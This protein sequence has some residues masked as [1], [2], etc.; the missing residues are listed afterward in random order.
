[1]AWPV[2]ALYEVIVA[3]VTTA[4]KTL[5]D[6]IQ[7]AIIGVV[8]GGKSIKKL[9]VDGVGDVASAVAA[10]DIKVSGGAY[11]DTGGNTIGIAGFQSTVGG[12]Q[13]AGDVK[14]TGG[15]CIG[16]RLQAD[17]T[18][19][20]ATAGAGQSLTIGQAWKDTLPV[21]WIWI[22]MIAGPSCQLGRGVNIAAAVTYNAAGSYTVT[23]TNGPANKLL[24]VAT[25][26]DNAASVAQ[27]KLT[28]HTTTSFEIN[29]YDMA[30]VATDPAIGGGVFVWL[31]GG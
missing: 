29:V 26:F 6:A 7:N 18:R 27:F 2:D 21:G 30:G 1:M 25:V 31:F 28:G 5:A 3:G 9:W 11:I 23:L 12:V 4:K 20:S 10:G 19:S 16:N 8:G 22:E 24:G 14:S 15:Y 13:V 17:N